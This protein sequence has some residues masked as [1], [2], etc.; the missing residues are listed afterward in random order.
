MKNRLLYV[1]LLL[2]FVITGCRSI[3]TPTTPN[4]P[5]FKDENEFQTEATI[6]FNGLNLKMAYTPVKHIAIQVNGQYSQEFNQQNPDGQYHKYLEGAVGAYYCFND[7]LVFE[8]YGG[9]GQGMSIFG[10]GIISN[11][12]LLTRAK[13]HYEKYY[14]QFNIGSRQL[15]RHGRIGACIRVGNVHY[16]YTDANFKWLV[17]TTS[18]HYLIEPYAFINLNMGQR[19]AFVGNLGITII[20]GL[21]NKPYKASMR[22]NIINIGVGFK[23]LLGKI[24]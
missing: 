3:Y 20:Q 24:D 14:A 1:N 21:S 2:L 16:T 9:F 5:L 19:V 4:I 18:D 10:D 11:E 17:N 12:E 8:V 15:L 23:V 6:F 7:D 22:T 13:G